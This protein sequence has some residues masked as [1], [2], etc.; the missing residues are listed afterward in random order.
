MFDNEFIL[1][2]KTDG[3]LLASKQGFVVIT[4]NFR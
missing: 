1:P 2:N 4:V 3:A